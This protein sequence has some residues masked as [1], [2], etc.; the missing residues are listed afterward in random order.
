MGNK[1][2]F[3]QWG[4]TSHEVL[5]G[6]YTEFEEQIKRIL[7]LLL[8]K[9]NVRLSDVKSSVFGL[10]GVDT[11][12]QHKII[13]DIIRNIGIDN[14]I[15]C[16]DAYLGIKAGSPR[17]TGVCVI[18]G[19]GN[20]IA[21]INA[22]GKMLQIGGQGEYTGDL[23][24]GGGIGSKAI[25]AVYNYLFKCSEYTIMS[26]ILFE[27]L[28]IKSKYDFIETVIYKENKGEINVGELSE[29]VFRAANME[30]TVAL[31]ILELVGRDCGR[32]I[33]GMLYE[34][35]FNPEESTDIVLAGSV[36]VKG[37]NSTLI[38]YMRREALAQREY[39][40]L[41]FIVLET[42]PVAGAIRWAYENL[43]KNNIY[44]EKVMSQL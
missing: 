37:E 43:D 24:G 9:N 10:A 17:G 23:G 36:N 31:G 21:G 25:K 33:R 32:A 5:K 11:R 38:D 18:N 28:G 2:D 1:I 40:N 42:P 39:R 41:N 22:E 30:D 27:L 13:S 4:T 7:D 3:L 12:E 20:T 8:T 34:L 16:N 44:F 35:N 15:L 29:I 6:G 14:F 26:D 19:T